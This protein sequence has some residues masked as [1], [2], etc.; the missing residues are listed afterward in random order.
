MRERDLHHQW[1]REET[2]EIKI[3]YVADADAASG[4]SEGRREGEE[5]AIVETRRHECKE[6]RRGW[7]TREEGEEREA[8]STSL[9]DMEEGRYLCVESECESECEWRQKKR[10]KTQTCMKGT[11]KGVE[12]EAPKE[13]A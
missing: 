13:A 4:E 6:Q 1:R 10:A 7:E 3:T 12:E 9:G 2:Q 5:R 11:E 8:N